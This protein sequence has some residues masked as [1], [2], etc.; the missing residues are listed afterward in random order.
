[1]LDALRQ[2][3]LLDTNSV[4]TLC[5]TKIEE[6][7]NPE[8][9]VS[10]IGWLRTWIEEDL[11]SAWNWF[12]YHVANL[13][14]NADRQVHEFA[15]ALI[16][17]KWLREPISDGDATTLVQISTMLTAHLPVPSKQG[18][19]DNNDIN[20]PI[21]RLRSSIPQILVQIRGAPANRALVELANRESDA[22]TKAWLNSRIV[23]HAGLEAQ[24]LAPVEPIKL[25]TLKLP[26]GSEPKS[27]YELFQQVI[28]RL[29]QLREGLEGGP[30]SDRLLFPLNVPEKHLQIWLAAR[31]ND[32][33]NPWF[34]VNREQVVDADKRTDVQLS[35]KYGNVCV[36][37]KPL[38][39]RSRSY[40]AKSLVKTLRTQIVGQYLKGLNSTHGILVLFRLETKKWV[41]PGMLK[42]GDFTDLLA[43]L[44]EQAKEVKRENPRIMELEVFG[45]DCVG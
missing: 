23:A 7:L 5:K 1:M 37:I 13:G 32:T 9:L 41:I 44:R 12:E 20:N 18:S 31:L 43:Y 15:Q 8:G 17:G 27:E 40:S 14:E 30:F 38:D 16:D 42:Q 45:I 39:R 29:E 33:T 28:G 35:C 36:E 3:G 21:V 34:S 6:S 22:F 11:H 19:N 10:E 2:D 4:V 25:K 26:F 24:Q